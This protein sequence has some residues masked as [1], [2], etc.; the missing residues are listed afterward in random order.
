MEVSISKEVFNPCFL[1]LLED[2]RHR[3]LVLY[4]GAGSGKSVLRYSGIFGGC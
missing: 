1:P 4:G 3:Y 2:D